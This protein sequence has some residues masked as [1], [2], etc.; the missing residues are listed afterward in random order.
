MRTVWVHQVQFYQ[1]T[2]LRLT[3]CSLCRFNNDQFCI[4]CIGQLSDR[5]VTLEHLQNIWL[6]LLCMAK[7]KECPFNRLDRLVLHR[8]YTFCIGQI[9]HDHLPL[10]HYVL[11]E[12]GHEFHRHCLNRWVRGSRVRLGCPYC[13]AEN[14]IPMIACQIHC[15]S[16]AQVLKIYQSSAP[17]VSSTERLGMEFARQ[18]WIMSFLKKTVAG[19]TIDDI[20]LESRKWPENTFVLS[21]VDES[22]ARLLSREFIH[23]VGDKYVHDCHHLENQ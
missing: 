15:K 16:S 3:L 18:S 5:E 19:R 10:C 20:Y 9:E 2:T 23:K 11:L 1:P 17:F 6:T 21:S 8:I 7:R 4:E 12:C 13:H 22:I 14:I